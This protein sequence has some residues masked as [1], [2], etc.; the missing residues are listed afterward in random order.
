M[1]NLIEP[2]ASTHSTF[3]NHESCRPPN[4]FCLADEKIVPIHFHVFIL[5]SN[6]PEIY[7]QRER[8]ASARTPPFTSRPYNHELISPRRR[9]IYELDVARAADRRGTTL[10]R[11][12]R[13][14]ARESGGGSL[15]RKALQYSGRE[16]EM[17]SERR[18]IL[19]FY[20][21]PRNNCNLGL[22]NIVNV[23]R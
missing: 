12:S 2:D 9:I 8:R 22:S 4:S 21:V 14:R 7:H 5:S 16:K 15:S 6:K 11:L 20:S 19:S 18:G 10:F 17:K 13:Q 23:A 3:R 1:L